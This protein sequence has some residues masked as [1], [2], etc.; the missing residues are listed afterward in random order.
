MLFKGGSKRKFFLHENLIF[1]EK[2]ALN[3]KKKV[4]G[5]SKLY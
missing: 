5:F 4:I 1:N 2:L 3:S